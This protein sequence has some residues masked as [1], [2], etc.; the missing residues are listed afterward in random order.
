MQIT[1]PDVI[2]RTF[3]RMAIKSIK[4]ANLPAR[5]ALAA[6]ML[7]CLVGVIFSLRWC[8]GNAISSNTIY[9][10]IA[11]L[12]ISLAPGDPQTHYAA[13]VL[14]ERTLKPDDFTKSL[15][16]Y[17]QSTALAP[18]DYRTWLALG[19]ARERGGDAAGAENALRKS[20]EL[21][22]NYSEVRW[23]LGNILLRRGETREAFA[24][25]KAAAENDPKF[26]N[27]TITTAWQIFGGDLTRINQN[28]GDSLS[29]KAALVAFLAR[30]KRFD[31]AAEIWKSLPAD[32]KRTTLKDNGGAFAAQLIEAK[33]YLD[34]LRVLAEIGDAGAE[35]F[36]VG[37][38]FNGGFEIDVKTVGASLFEWQ[39]QEGA[40]PQIGIDG[41]QKHGGQRSLVAVFNS[42]TGREFRPVSQT[43]AVE[44]GNKYTFEMF[45]KSELKTDA[46]FYWQIVSVPE[47][48]I[49]AAT[50]A[51]SAASDWTNLKTEFVAPEKMEAVVVSLARETCKSTLCPIS[52]RVWFDD[53]TLIR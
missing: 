13:A 35:N 44:P 22:P 16:E 34:A 32:Q 53:L 33:K 10:E 6:A 40:Q 19:R 42:A 15:A 21:A 45:Y 52:G 39:I 29:I 7:L 5:I 30:E 20:L 38:I 18:N 1:V 26:V 49:L 12:A 31:E 41:L 25:L 24:N 47:G 2:F 14:R 51:I 3:F 28:L 4:T 50:P 46:T 48:K 9:L 11:D 8:V 36:A 37:R 27:P 23:I 17:E 43:V